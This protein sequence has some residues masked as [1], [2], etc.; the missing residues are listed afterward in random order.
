MKMFNKK[1]RDKNEDYCNYF[2][3]VMVIL[4]VVV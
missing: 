4:I 2:E 1:C 3:C